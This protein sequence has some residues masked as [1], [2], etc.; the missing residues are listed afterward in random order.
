MGILYRF[1]KRNTITII[2]YLY[3]KLLKIQNIRKV[4]YNNKS[5]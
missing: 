2:F 3:F 4:D 5:I 1:N